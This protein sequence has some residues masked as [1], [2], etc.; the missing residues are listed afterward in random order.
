MTA[1]VIN[2]DYVAGLE[3]LTE[4]LTGKVQKT[5]LDRLLRDYIMPQ[6]SNAL[7]VLQ[8]DGFRRPVDFAAF[9]ER[10]QSLRTVNEVSLLALSAGSLELEVRILTPS[11]LL[12]K[13]LNDFHSDDLPFT[14]KVYP[15]T[16]TPEHYLVRAI[17]EST[18]DN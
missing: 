5:C 15:L 10:L 3:Q 18:L 6:E 2:S 8:C 7:V 17:Y 13:W 4:N 12:I 11:L 16:K 14:L 1:K 9:K